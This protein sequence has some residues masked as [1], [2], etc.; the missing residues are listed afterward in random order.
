MRRIRERKAE[1]KTVWGVSPININ[2]RRTVIAKKHLGSELTKQEEGEER[3]VQ[4]ETE[5]RVRFNSGSNMTRAVT[6]GQDTPVTSHTKQRKK[7]R[8]SFDSLK[9]SLNFLKT[10]QTAAR[11]ERRTEATAGQPEV[12]GQPTPQ[13]LRLLSDRVMAEFTDLYSDSPDDSSNLS[14][15]LQS[16]VKLDFS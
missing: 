15:L 8:K 10:P 6:P 5:R 9:C 2:T 14:D 7:S 12:R 13:A 3:T 4:A 1:F 16:K 11:R